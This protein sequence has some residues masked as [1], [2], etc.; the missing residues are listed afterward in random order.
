MEDYQLLITGPDINYI[1][2]CNTCYCA[3]L[4]N[5]KW[6][7]AKILGLSFLDVDVYCL[8]HHRMPLSDHS[9]NNVN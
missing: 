7:C 5:T 6:E 1:Q 8:N 3:Q 2:H 4:T 9:K